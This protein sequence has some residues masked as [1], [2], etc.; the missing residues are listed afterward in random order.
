M[1]ESR[2][3]MAGTPN[4][5]LSDREREILACLAEGLSNRQIGERLSLALDTVKWYASQL[6]RK[7]GVS[8]RGQAVEQARVRGL[9]DTPAS[10]MPVHHR[11]NLPKQTPAFVG[12]ERELEAI[13]ALLTTQGVRLVTILAPGGMGKTRLV[14]AAAEQQLPHFQDGVCFVPLAPLNS[15]DN[16]VTTIAENLGLSFDGSTTP[17]E[18][19]LTYL[20]QRSLL[21]VLDNI[22][23]LLEGVS[24]VTDILQAAAGVKILVTSREK[25][26]LSDETVFTLA[27]LSFPDS[28]TS[29]DVQA[30]DAIRLF[31]QSARQ[32]R[33]EFKLSPNDRAALMRIA[34]LT[35]GM[36]LA[37]VLAAG[38][39][40]AL[41]LERV[42]S[43]LEHSIDILETELRDVPERQRSVRATFDQSWTHYPIHDK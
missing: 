1:V 18:Q 34:Q 31:L 10:D 9:L 27:G 39:V 42:V 26:H 30:Y 5:S 15:P 36:P 6:Y 8:R 40:D 37:L 24:L 20:R 23:H 38:W 7:L 33:P 25:L 4:D 43:E 11:H 16:M 2:R 29:T 41:S 3:G 21:L 14:L 19:L 28:E 17:K 13:R 32:A 22:E 35:A 12:R